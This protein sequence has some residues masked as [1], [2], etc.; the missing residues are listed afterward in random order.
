VTHGH[1]SDLADSSRSLPSLALAPTRQ[2]SYEARGDDSRAVAARVQESVGSL[3]VTPTVRQV[4]YYAL[5]TGH[6]LVSDA[7]EHLQLEV[8]QV[9]GPQ[10]GLVLEVSPWTATH[11]MA[12]VHGHEGCAD[13]S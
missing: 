7:P 2:K 5:V 8:V 12:R 4:Y 11:P 3:P 9:F 6:L 10:R 13:A 1:V